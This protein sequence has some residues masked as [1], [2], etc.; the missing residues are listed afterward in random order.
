[1]ANEYFY[2]ASLSVVHPTIDP[3]TISARITSLSPKIETLAGTQRLGKNGKPLVPP[4]KAAL[5]H[6][7]ADLHAEQTLNSADRPISE[8]ILEKLRGL[9]MHRDFFAQL[10]QEGQVILVVHWFAITNYAADVFSAETLKKCGELGID[11]E[12]NFS[13]LSDDD[14]PCG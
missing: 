2:C 11:I 8:F 3:R 14:G 4:R 10:R 6:W 7:A 13:C 1:M 5:S 12:L 9:E